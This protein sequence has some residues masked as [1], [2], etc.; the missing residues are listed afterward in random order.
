MLLELPWRKENRTTNCAGEK[1][2]THCANAFFVSGFAK[3]VESSAVNDR[4]PEPRGD[5]GQEQFLALFLPE[6]GSIRAFIRSAVWDPA[7]CDDIFQEVALV[8]WREMG[9]YDPTRPF[10]AWA[11]GVAAKTILKGLREVRRNAGALSP[12]AVAALEKA[13]D[14]T[15]A[16]QTRPPS[17]QAEALQCCLE[18]LP[19]RARSLVHLRYG[20]ALSVPDIASRV[21]KSPDAVQKALSRLRELLA[22]CVE[23]RMKAGRMK[24]GRMKAGWKAA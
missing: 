17:D 3:P 22:K 19:D 21:M 23:R 11:R 1:F 13:F 9:R 8:L 14:E 15:A 4:L 6:Q 2:V 5:E 10:G 18:R 16:T 20:D 7:R 12:E 24:A